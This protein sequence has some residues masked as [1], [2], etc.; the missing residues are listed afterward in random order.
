MS[1]INEY[2]KSQH[3][4]IVVA[5]FLVFALFLVYTI[6]WE[7]D[8]LSKYGHFKRA[9]ATVVRHYEDEEDG[10]IYDV[11]YFETD[12]KEYVEK[13]TPFESKYDI[14]DTFSVFYDK[15]TEIE[16][17]YK[18]NIKFYLLPII[19]IVFGLASGGLLALYIITYKKK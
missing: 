19:T 14:S 3:R 1:Q 16:V 7:I 11:Y 17:I 2:K 10:K 15:N 8:Y 13:I 5:C 18:R 4:L 9:T 12:N 6:I